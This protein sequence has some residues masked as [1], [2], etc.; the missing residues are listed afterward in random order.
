MGRI[1]GG[2]TCGRARPQPPPV[3]AAGAGGGRGDRRRREGRPFWPEHRSSLPADSNGWIAYTVFNE[4]PAGG[5]PDTDVWLAALGQQPRR[6]VGSDTDGVDQACPAFSPDGRS[7][8][9]GSVEGLWSTMAPTSPGGRPIGTPRSSSPTWPTMARSPIGSPSTS[10]TGSRRPA[11]SG[12]PTATELAFGAPL[13]SPRNPRRS[14]EGSEMW[15]LRPAD[16]HV[17]VIP[18]LLATDLEWSPDGSMLAI[19]SGV[20]E[21]VYGR[22]LQDGRIPSTRPPPGRCDRS[23]APLGAISLTWAPDGDRIAYM[24]GDP[25]RRPRSFASWTWRPVSRRSWPRAFDGRSRHRT[26][27]VT[28]RRDDRLPAD[29][30]RDRRGS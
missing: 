2:A 5:D 15:I 24:S 28:G 11:P 12:R 20:D 8:A 26:G 29:H 3:A 21:L 1:T 14:G 9:Y 10:A 4:D 19:A 27:V 13:T 25:P 6:V 23:T 30:Q 16:G 17:T 7:L 18:D 22:A